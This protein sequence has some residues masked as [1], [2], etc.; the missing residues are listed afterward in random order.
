M[1]EIDKDTNRAIIRAVN[2]IAS[3]MGIT[4]LAEGVETEEQFARVANK[5][6]D[7]VQGYT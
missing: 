1:K 5:R 7:E 3:A 6:C 4:T 2:S